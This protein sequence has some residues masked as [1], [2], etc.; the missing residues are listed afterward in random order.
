VAGAVE[1]PDAKNRVKGVIPRKEVLQTME[2]EEVVEVQEERAPVPVPAQP[3]MLDQ[4][5]LA[6]R[7]DAMQAAIER[8]TGS[9]AQAIEPRVVQGM[10]VAP[11]QRISVG[12]GSLEQIELATVALL[13]GV[14][15]ALGVA[16]LS[17]VRELYH[18][19]SGDYRM[20]GLFDPDHVY[21]AN[22]N[23]STMAGLVANALN[24]KL[25]N[26]F[27]DFPRW[28]AKAVTI[29]N[30]T[31]LQDVRWITLGGIGE[32]PTVAAGAAYTELTWDDST[33][34][35]A[36]VKKGGYLGITLEAIDKDD[37]GRLRA[38]PRA[39]ARSAW[40]TLSKSISAIFTDASGLGP[41][42]ADTGTLF[43]AT[44]VTTTGGHA[45]LSTTAALSYSN[46]KT[47]RIAMMKQAELHSGER[48]G[49]L[50]A[51]YLLWVPIDLEV[52]AL[53]TLG[54]A[55]EPGSADYDTN[56]FAEG[57]EREARISSA[58]DRVIVC[59]LWTD[60]DNWAAQ[61]DPRLYP[62]IGLGYRFGETPEIY[63]VAS[64]TGGLMFTNDTLP[65]KVRYFF[66]VGPTDWRGLYKVNIA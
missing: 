51:P 60:T 4:V 56:V 5:A 8:L 45:N 32:L 66:A 59:P 6:Q 46:W 3:S 41:T 37:T 11:R 52:T 31:S 61:A 24:K 58:R 43:N 7:I 1:V 62:S 33:E 48:L 13:N 38:A 34:T 40:L 53:Q 50:T 57:N 39:L 36:F 2:P 44:A 64:P 63:S 23:E 65:I 30:F 26:E 55:G 27:Q 54:S 20:T 19:L 42:M 17:G 49:A 21:L 14:S 22:V 12:P 18:L 35:D 29:E 15:P 28:W 47:V 9:L 10:G 16:P 25:I